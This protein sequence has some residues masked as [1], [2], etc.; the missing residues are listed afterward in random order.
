V[1]KE[2][3][4]TTKARLRSQLKEVVYFRLFPDSYKT[5]SCLESSAISHIL[6]IPRKIYL[7]ICVFSQHPSGEIEKFMKKDPRS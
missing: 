5:T 2:D 7:D 4:A 1:K 6:N 3:V